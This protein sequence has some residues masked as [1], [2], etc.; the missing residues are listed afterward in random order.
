MNDKNKNK[1]FL[2][3]FH[4]SISKKFINGMLFQVLLIIQIFIFSVVTLISG[5]QTLYSIFNYESYMSRYAY[6]Y[7]FSKFLNNYS[8]EPIM[9]MGR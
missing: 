1:E 3:S 6:N 8:K 7:E 2:S 4:F 9:N 5:Y